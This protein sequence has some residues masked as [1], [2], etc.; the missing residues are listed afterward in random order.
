MTQTVDRPAGPRAG[1]DEV[2]GVHC[3]KGHFNDPRVYYCGVCGM[4]MAQTTRRP[5]LAARPQ[6][7]VL[8]VDDGT[9]LPVLGNLV[10]GR[11]P[12]A[13]EEVAQGRA[14][15]VPL[16]D[17]TLSRVHVKVVLKGWDVMV[18]D[19][20][21]SNGT[22]VNTPGEGWRRLRR[23]SAVPLRPG[24]EVAVGHRRFCF[25]SNRNP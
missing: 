19:A 25:Y 6:L 8:V 5:V 11:A 17:P 24:A 10:F 2:L 9:M 21:S 4:A 14:T 16:S 18:E 1:V 23:G 3:K 13:A 20:G 22:F 12:D 15:A 7:G